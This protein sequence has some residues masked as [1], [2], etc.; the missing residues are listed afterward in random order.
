MPGRSHESTTSSSSLTVHFSTRTN[1][2][3]E[4]FCAAGGPPPARARAAATTAVVRPM[5]LQIQYRFRMIGLL[6]LIYGFIGVSVY[7]CYQVCAL[8]EDFVAADSSFLR[9]SSTGNALF[10]PPATPTT[11][12]KEE[13]VCNSLQNKHFLNRGFRGCA[14]INTIDPAV[15]SAAIRV[16]CGS[17][18]CSPG[19]P[20]PSGMPVRTI[21]FQR[22]LANLKLISSASCSFVMAR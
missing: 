21:R 20:R 8:R 4:A 15:S 12:R 16:I 6:G 1:R 22:S 2:A 3:V 19:S 13:H 14:R 17:H 18:F 5:P 10:G 9:F 7:L 11:L